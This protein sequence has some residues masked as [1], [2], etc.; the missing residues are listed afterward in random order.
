MPN[1]YPLALRERA[2]R[3]YES[4]SESYD[5]VAERFSIATSTLERWVARERATGSVAALPK[6]GGWKSQID[7]E[8][9]HA[10]VAKAPDATAEELT[11]KYNRDAARSARVHVSSFKRA[12]KRAGFV[13]KKNGGGRRSK[14]GRTSRRSGG[15]SSAG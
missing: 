2:V 9:L 3:A 4:G 12:L 10:V 13:F 11:R 6:G 14:T 5:E 15:R 1:P 8:L 7:M